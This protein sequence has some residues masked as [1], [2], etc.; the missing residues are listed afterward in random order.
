MRECEKG[1]FSSSRSVSDKTVDI[2]AGRGSRGFATTSKFSVQQCQK[3]CLTKG[4][5]TDRLLIL[6]TCTCK[7]LCYDHLYQVTVKDHLLC[8]CLLVDIH[9]SWKVATCWYI[10]LSWTREPRFMLLWIL[11]YSDFSFVSDYDSATYRERERAVVQWLLFCCCRW[12]REGIIIMLAL[13]MF[14]GYLNCVKPQ[15]SEKV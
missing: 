9:H 4:W 8:S 11:G 5:Y 13:E 1:I 7:Y 14:S 10:I 12:I 3:N 15:S 6:Y 2:H